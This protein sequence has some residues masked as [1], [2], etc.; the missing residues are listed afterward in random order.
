VL[1]TGFRV[2]SVRLS[3]VLSQVGMHELHDIQSN[4]SLEH[5]GQSDLG[6]SHLRTVVHV[7]YGNQRSSGH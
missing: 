2:H 1:H 3:L 4:R 5:G 6:A 7:K